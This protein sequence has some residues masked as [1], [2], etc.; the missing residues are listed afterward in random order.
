MPKF[1]VVGVQD[2]VSMDCTAMEVL[3]VPADPIGDEGLS[4]VIVNAL[5]VN[6][7]D[8]ASPSFVTTILH[9]SYVPGTNAEKVIVLSPAIATVV[10]LLQPPLYVMRPACVV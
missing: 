6:G 10:V 3:C 7:V 9:A 4:P 2:M 1:T 8:A 5:T